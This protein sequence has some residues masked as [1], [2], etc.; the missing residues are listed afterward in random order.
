MTLRTL[1]HL[2]HLQQFT[3]ATKRILKKKKWFYLW[4]PTNL[5]SKYSSLSENAQKSS[6]NTLCN[7]SIERN[8]WIF[9]ILSLLSSLKSIQMYRIQMMQVSVLKLLKYSYDGVLAGN[10][11]YRQQWAW[12]WNF[13]ET[14]EE[15][16]TNILL[17]F[18][19]YFYYILLF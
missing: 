17:I 5:R 1:Q 4:F 14:G 10:C 3:D 6:F 7:T 9:W 13:L 12:R 18:Y 8:I 2:K 19:F 15:P 16:T 11:Q